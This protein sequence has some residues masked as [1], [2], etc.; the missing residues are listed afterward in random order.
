MLKPR[1]SRGLR[2]IPKLRT[3]KVKRQNRQ[4]HQWEFHVQQARMQVYRHHRETSRQASPAFPNTGEWP[5]IEF[6]RGPTS[7]AV[8]RKVQSHD[9]VNEPCAPVGGGDRK[10]QLVIAARHGVRDRRLDSTTLARCR[11]LETCNFFTDYAILALSD[12]RE[13][14]CQF[15]VSFP[16]FLF[17]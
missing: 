12:G 3:L 4:S 10:K 5:P 6:G 9:D 16:S 7:Y 15:G 1:S 17:A 8:V 14:A 13:T 2:G 11:E